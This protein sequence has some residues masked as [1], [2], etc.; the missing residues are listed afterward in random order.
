MTFDS[1]EI[2]A[3]PLS[4]VGRGIDDL[5]HE[6]YEQCVYW[7]KRDEPAM[8]ALFSAL[9]YE[10]LV[11]PD[12]EAI[13]A[14]V[15]SVRRLNN[16][17]L[18]TSEV[19]GTWRVTLFDD[20][21]QLGKE[22]QNFTKREQWQE[23][24]ND[25]IR[26]VTNLTPSIEESERAE[27]LQ[28][29]L[30]SESTGTNPF[31]RA[32]PDEL[33]MQALNQ[34][35][36]EGYHWLD[37]GTGMV[38]IPNQVLQK[39]DFPFEPAKLYG[40]EN[41]SP[42]VKEWTESAKLTKAAKRL[43][44]RD[45]LVQWCL[46]VDLVDPYRSEYTQ[47]RS[48]ASLR[49]SELADKTFMNTYLGLA[50]KQHPKL[51]YKTADLTL[52]HDTEKLRAELGDTKF[53][54]ITMSTVQHQLSRQERRDMDRNALSLLA[55]GGILF[56]KD[57]LSVSPNQPH[58][59]RFFKNWHQKG[60][61]R[62]FVYDPAHSDLGWQEFCRNYDSR[63]KDIVIG[64]GRIAVGGRMR[65]FENLISSAGELARR[66]AVVIDLAA[67]KPTLHSAS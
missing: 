54:I 8:A 41:L 49:G 37:I 67:Q 16:D 33:L 22:P 1:P 59:Q 40:S 43:L 46:A 25:L 32:T 29:S 36:R 28:I 53:D 6:F 44:A 56:K 34:R 3:K 60:R 4:A 20:Q 63:C 23:P 30:I 14:D 12:L 61:Y 42:G 21:L 65:Q 13:M 62:G 17:D 66:E 7:E 51:E 15:V 57:F 58:V 35:F 45:H 9:F 64:S 26:L 55:P 5:K 11:N 47:K 50:A 39:Q 24:L 10:S 19:A 27:R 38:E 31:S 52:Q 2:G 48:L 18:S